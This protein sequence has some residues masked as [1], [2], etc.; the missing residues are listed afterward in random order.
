MFISN[1]KRSGVLR[2]VYLLL[3]VCTHAKTLP[4]SHFLFPI[5]NSVPGT[6]LPHYHQVG[7][8]WERQETLAVYGVYRTT[9]I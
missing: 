6:F 3:H 7:T 8:G 9:V 1:F 5:N 4:Q 2:P